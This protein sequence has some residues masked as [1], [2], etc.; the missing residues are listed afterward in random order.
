[1][2]QRRFEVPPTTAVSIGVLPE[3]QSLDVWPR[4]DFQ[5]EEVRLSPS[6]KVNWDV[7]RAQ[8]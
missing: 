7:V 4:C 1:M 3:F 2:E 6:F 8:W 5:S